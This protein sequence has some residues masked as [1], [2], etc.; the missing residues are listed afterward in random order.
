MRKLLFFGV[1]AACWA[2]N[3]LIYEAYLQMLRDGS[4]VGAFQMG[5]GVSVFFSLVMQI[6]L[7]GA[8]AF[9][10][11]KSTPRWQIRFLYIS[12]GLA[13]AAFLLPV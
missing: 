12:L 4:Q 1:L 6:L 11:R 10:V 2:L 7:F 8:A 3:F 9:L 5:W 13:L